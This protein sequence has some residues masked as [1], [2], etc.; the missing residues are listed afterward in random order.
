M[1]PVLLAKAGTMTVKP[2]SPYTTEGMPTNKSVAGRM[3]SRTQLGAIL[4][5]K[6][7]PDKASGTDITMDRKV[8]ISVLYRNG[9][10]PNSPLEGVQS[11]E[12]KKAKGEISR[13]VLTP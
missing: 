13:K 8:S 11:V 3:I 6:T 4:A 9:K 5:M 2:I 12:K 10:I 1:V 7:A